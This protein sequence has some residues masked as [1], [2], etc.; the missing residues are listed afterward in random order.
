[1]AIRFLYESYIEI[2]MSVMLML[3]TIEFG[4]ASSAIRHSFNF[5]VLA[6]L[7][8]FPMVVTT[9]LVRN[10]KR[11]EQESFKQKYG[12]YY[13]SFGIRTDSFSSILNPLVFMLRR[14]IVAIIAIFL[15]DPGT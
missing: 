10:R 9:F 3:K 1:M 4:S 11:L 7:A 12:T 8:G 15:S 13:R 5:F 2:A 14:I 6:L